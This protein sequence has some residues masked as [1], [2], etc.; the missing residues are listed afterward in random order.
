MATP[1]ALDADFEACLKAN[2]LEEFVGGPPLPPGDVDQRRKRLKNLS[3]RRPRPTVDT[4]G[5]DVSD[6]YT[7]SEDGHRVLL[8]W[9]CPRSTAV[10]GSHTA[11]LSSSS[12]PAVIYIHGGGLICSTIN[13]YDVLVA[14]LV[15]MTRT[16]FL[17]VEYRLAPEHRYPAALHDVYAA[18]AWLHAR[19]HDLHV[20]RTR[21]AIMGSSAGAGLGAATAILARRRGGG[22]SIAKQI[23]TAPMIDCRN[24]GR[25]DPRL[26]PLLSWN[27]VDNATGWSSYLG[28]EVLDGHE[29]GDGI[30]D[31]ASPSRLVSA[32][33][34]PALYLEVG[35]LDMFVQEGI[36]YASKHVRAGVPVELHV[37]PGLPHSYDSLGGQCQLARM[38]KVHRLRAITS[39]RGE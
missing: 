8:R 31:T 32:E 25:H 27:H 35:S 38:A 2:G 6:H 12:S 30:P 17:A 5:V 22:L 28:H 7:S 26:A 11:T 20:D 33:G 14:S 36:E 13:D 15:S 3:S 9:Y 24:V 37:Y 29:E 10:N 4:S 1:F 21:I 16:P 39:L 23:F 34:M 19:A 18:L